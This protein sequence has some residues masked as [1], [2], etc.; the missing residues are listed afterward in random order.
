MLV[1]FFFT[2]FGI[3]VLPEFMRDLQV[4]SPGRQHSHHALVTLEDGGRDL[5]LA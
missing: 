5:G 1:S 2:C 4:P 3:L